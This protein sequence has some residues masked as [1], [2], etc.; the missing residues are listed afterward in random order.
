MD[1][2][3]PNLIL[4]SARCSSPFPDGVVQFHENKIDPPSRAYLKLWESFTL[5]PKRPGPGDLCLDLGSAPAAGHGCSP[6]SARRFSA[7]TKPHSPRR[8]ITC[9]A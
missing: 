4:A 5:L 6:A 7:S 9:P 3:E 2:V 8:W 1:T